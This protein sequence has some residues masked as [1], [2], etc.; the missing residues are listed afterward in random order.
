MKRSDIKKYG[1]AIVIS[2]CFVLLIIFP[3]ILT[4]LKLI[5]GKELDRPLKGNFDPVETPVFS[6]ENFLGKSFQK[7]FEN[8]FHNSFT[9]RGYLTTT[10][11][12]IRHSLFGENPSS[13]IGDSLIWESYII[14]HMGIEP[15]NYNNAERMNEMKNYVE[16]L[17]TISDWLKG[18]GKSLI[19]VTA[20]GKASWFEDD[21]PSKYFLMPRGLDAESCLD[22]LISQKDI[23]YLNSDQYLTEINF[24]YPVFYKSS[25]HWSRTAEVEIE[26]K[27]FDIINTQTPFSV[28]TYDIESVIESPTPVD[29]D[30]DA[31]NLV[32]LWIPTNETY[33]KYDIN[34][35]MVPESTNIC[36]L[37]DSFTE[38]IARDLITNGHNGIVSSIYYDDAYYVNNELVTLIED[39]F[40]HIDIE[41][42]LDENDIFIFMYTDYNLPHCGFGSVDAIYN[43]LVD[44]E[45][46]MWSPAETIWLSGED[47]NA[48]QYIAMGIGQNEGTHTWFEGNEVCFYDRS[49][50]DG[51]SQTNC[52]LVLSIQNTLGEQRII[53]LVNGEE[54]YSECIN[55]QAEVAIPFSTD[56]SG[57]AQISIYL[58]DAISPKELGE[59]SDSRVLSL[60]L[61]SILFEERRV[62][63]DE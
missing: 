36:F 16:K 38:L 49:F 53:A 25:Y 59:S 34:V 24:Q 12:Q 23:L 56:E 47:W 54:V 27:I 45:E 63:T 1:N 14:I 2:V 22:E 5:T 48:D 39:D 60:D 28:E 8:Y 51:Y 9:G 50:G 10:Y 41:K 32:N 46:E 4:L 19:F 61:T 15:Y 43:C 29:R 18:R 55:G 57:L 13:Y 35:N 40:S 31:L 20:S 33:Y 11:N 42:I 17:Q 44:L 7:D 6:V 58:P 62:E 37:G 52:R 21:I 30:A 3:G 26:N